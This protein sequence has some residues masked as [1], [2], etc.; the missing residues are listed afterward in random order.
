M[1]QSRKKW[2]CVEPAVAICCTPCVYFC[3]DPILVANAPTPLPNVALGGGDTKR[4]REEFVPKPPHETIL[5]MESDGVWGSD[6][7]VHKTT[8]LH[9]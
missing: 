7:C 8:G 6:A 9:R 2:R 3:V 4:R 1:R 5:P